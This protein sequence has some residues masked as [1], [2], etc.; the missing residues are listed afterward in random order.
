M[1]I[2]NFSPIFIDLGFFQLRW[3]SIAYIMGIALGWWFA[4]KIIENNK[5]Y[6]SSNIT[7]KIF[8][9]LIIYLIIGI[10]I[11]GRI[12]YILFYNLEYYSENLIDAFK[13]WKGGMSFHGGLIGVVLGTIIF[14]KIKKISFFKLADIIACVSPIGIFFGRLANFINGELYGKVSAVPWA[15]IFPKI[16]NFPRHPSQIYEAAL[17]GLILLLIINFFSLRKNM[18]RQEGYV[19]GIFLIFY[20][21]FR[22]FAE[23]FREPDNHIGYL[24]NYYSMGMIL[25]FFTLVSGLLIILYIKKNEK[26]N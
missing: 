13:L 22:L 2:H 6:K 18:I 16:D 14:S 17:E 11:G 3:Y 21:I 23:I 25:S 5:I 24:F 19:S 26:N 7:T 1:I 4:N 15:I 10:I 12:G 8:D 20:S 9:D